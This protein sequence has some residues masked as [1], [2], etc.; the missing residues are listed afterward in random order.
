MQLEL[1]RIHRDVGITFV[2]VTHDQEEALTMSDRI[3]V[4]NGGRVVQFDT[5]ATVYQRP[6][7]AFVAGFVGVS[8][9]FPGRIVGADGDLATVALDG[10]PAVALAGLAVIAVLDV[11]AA[12]VLRRAER[13]VIAV[14]SVLQLATLAIGVLSGSLMFL[15]LL[16]AGVWIWWL[17]TRRS[18]AA[19]VA[20]RD[21][22]TSAVA[23]PGAGGA[24]GTPR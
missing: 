17:A 18:Y 5:P 11:V 15:G 3:A 19:A 9:F 7:T 6:T 24:G 21:A 20:R 2:Y 1:K 4:M 8:N 23:P 22:G 10:A 12:G 16:F 13:E 14:G